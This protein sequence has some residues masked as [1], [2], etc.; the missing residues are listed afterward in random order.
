MRREGLFRHLF[1]P[2][3]AEGSLDLMPPKNSESTVGSLDLMPPQNGLAKLINGHAGRVRHK[4]IS[5]ET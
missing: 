3:L 1:I 4:H 2:R 5:R